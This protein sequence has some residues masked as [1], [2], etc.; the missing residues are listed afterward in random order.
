MATIVLL[1]VIAGVSAANIYYNQPMLGIMERD[2]GS[3][4]FT[5]L[6]ALSLPS[7]VSVYWPGPRVALDTEPTQRIFAL[8]A[9]RGRA[10]VVWNARCD[11]ALGGDAY[12]LA[13]G[14][15]L[16]QHGAEQL[17]SGTEPLAAPVAAVHRVVEVV[18]HAYA[19][20]VGV[21][22]AEQHAVV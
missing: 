8:A 17:F 21:L 20:Q 9:Q 19:E 7:H 12:L 16:T 6:P 14:R 22:L 4:A 18:V 15:R 13:Q 5:G 11:A 1:G 2:L 10:L 3:P